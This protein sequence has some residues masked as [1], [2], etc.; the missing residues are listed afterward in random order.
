MNETFGA[1]VL[2]TEIEGNIFEEVEFPVE[3]YANDHYAMMQ[4]LF[5]IETWKF[6]WDI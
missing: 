2:R 3:D 6:G 5:Y 4:E 1:F